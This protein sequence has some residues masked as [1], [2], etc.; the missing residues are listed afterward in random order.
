MVTPTLTLTDANID[1]TP[2]P[3]A[4]PKNAYSQTLLSWMSCCCRAWEAVQ[5]KDL[6]SGRVGC[7]K[8]SHQDVEGVTG[9]LQ[10]KDLTKLQ[11]LKITLWIN[12]VITSEHLLG[13]WS[14]LG[15]WS[16]W[17]SELRLGSKGWLR[18]WVIR[19]VTI[20]C[21]LRIRF[22][23]KGHDSKDR[24]SRHDNRT[25]TGQRNRLIRDR[26]KKLRIT[27]VSWV[28]VSAPEG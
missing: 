5:P 10:P 8:I 28:L 20:V 6:T 11:S 27:P 13:S 22:T 3:I 17:R 4:G 19:M 25:G 14:Y 26:L 15:S 12:T 24:G 21:W 7:Q 2:N 18:L 1:T 23:V 9:R 16:C